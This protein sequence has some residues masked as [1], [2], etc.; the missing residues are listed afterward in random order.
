MRRRPGALPAL[1][2]VLS[3]VVLASP[4][5]ASAQETVPGLSIIIGSSP[6][7]VGS[8]A[9][10]VGMGSA[11]VAIADDATAASW[12][13]AGLVQLERPEVSV[14][15][16][17][18][19]RQEDYDSI[20]IPYSY[21]QAEMGA[22]TFESIDVNYLSLVYP[23]ALLGRNIVVSLNYHRTFDF[24]RQ[25]RYGVFYKEDFEKARDR[26]EIEFEFDYGIAQEGGLAAA[27]AAFAAELT[28]SLSFGVA[29]SFWMDE[30]FAGKTWEIR[31]SRSGYYRFD[32]TVLHIEDVSERTYRDFEGINATL[33]LLWRTGKRFT[34]GAKLDLPFEAKLTQEL[35]NITPERVDRKTARMHMEFPLMF[36]V[37][38]AFRASDT[39]TLSADWTRIEWGDYIFRDDRE[40]RI[41][42]I[43]GWLDRDSSVEATNTLR[44]GCEYL[45][46]L[47]RYV[48][49]LRGGLFYDP[50]PSNENPTDFFGGSVG[51]GLSWQDMSVDLA[52]QF[53][54]GLDVEGNAY[55]VQ[56]EVPEARAAVTQ[57]L[58]LLSLIYY[59]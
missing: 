24:G 2:L 53:R 58:F 13:P 41:S 42:P 40:N 19:A 30:L 35:T 16:S 27:S 21:P 6:N 48:V 14:V 22:A 52:Y 15:G 8:G 23:F 3:L 7:P 5:P 38:A 51:G 55:D 32:E 18:T 28:Q 59:L 29:V 1:S 4:G 39:L 25:V 31:D 45:F 50:E 36:A 20:L 26:T 46:V 56:H 37:G 17:Y 9:R 10:A 12:N 47:P 49:A 44:T 33:G 43:T 54:R 34:F 57:H 11:F